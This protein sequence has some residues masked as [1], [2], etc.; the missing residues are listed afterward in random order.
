MSKRGLYIKIGGRLCI[1]AEK[2]VGRKKN[3]K[4]DEDLL[5]CDTVH[6]FPTSCPDIRPIY[7]KGMI[8]FPRKEYLKRTKR[9][10]REEIPKG[11]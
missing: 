8:P 6:F 1:D 11:F 2:L 7:E 5:F 3:K 9:D 4:Y 10:C